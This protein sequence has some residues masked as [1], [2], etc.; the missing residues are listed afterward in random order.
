[1]EEFKKELD[2]TCLYIAG[3]I[4]QYYEDF[5]SDFETG[6]NNIAF[7]YEKQTIWRFVERGDRCLSI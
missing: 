4:Q 6:I 2:F 7:E 5:D 1:M 3:Y